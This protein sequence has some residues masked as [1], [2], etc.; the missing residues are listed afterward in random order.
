MTRWLLF[1]LSTT[2]VA[3]FQVQPAAALDVSEDVPVP[4]GIAAVVRVLGVDQ[5]IDRGR[6]VS[7][8][9]RLLYGLPD[10]RTAVADALAQR[11][12]R[13]SSDA[14]AAADLVPVPLTA[15]VWSTAVFHRPVGPADLIAAIIGDRQAALLCHGLAG[16][17]DETLQYLSGHPALITQIYERDAE[18]FSVFASSLHVR[19]G[20]VVPP[21]GDLAAPLWEG[22]LGERLAQPDRFVPALF[23]QADGRTAFLYDTIAALDGPRA[24]FAL[25]LWI[26]DPAARVDAMKRLALAWTSGLRD[27]RVRVQ[28][29]ARQPYDVAA[30]LARV[31]A[32]NDG[33]PAPPQSRALWSR[34]F[35]KTSD[36]DR[37]VDAAWLID[38]TAPVDVR[39][40]HDRLD[41]LAFAQRVFGSAAP[42]D[43]A[44][45]LTALRAF[46]RDRMLMLTFERIGVTQPSM[47]AAAVRRVAAMTPLDTGRAFAATAQFQGALALITRMRLAGT[48]DQAATDRLV[49]SLV[50]VPLTAGGRYA[51]GVTRWLAQQLRPAIPA[52]DTLEDALV[53]AAAGP[54]G[55]ASVNRIQWEG[56]PYVVDLGAAERR[57]IARVREKQG[58]APIDAA[59]ELADVA[60]AC[61]SGTLAPDGVQAATA[62]L[63]S[64]A[65]DWPERSV[66]D[67]PDA[68]PPGV[69]ARPNVRDLI[70]RVVSE[71]DKGDARDAKRAQRVAGALHDAADEATA[72]VLVSLVYAVH[73]GDPDGSALLAGD[74]S[75]RH[76]FGF[77][78]KDADARMRAPWAVPR[79][80]VTPGLA[81]HV[82]GSLLGL[83]VAL[84]TLELRRLSADRALDA[85]TLSANERDTFATSAALVNASAL[86][87][88]ARDAALDAVAR[89]RRRVAAAGGPGDIADELGIDGWRRRSL[90]WTFQHDRGNVESMFSLGELLV[91]GD[92]A[93]ALDRDVWGMAAVA[94]TGCVC[95]EMP[96]PSR[97]LALTGRAQLGVLATAVVDLNLHVAERLKQL[98]LP[99]RLAKFVLGAAVQDFVDE[100]RPSDADDWLT[101]VRTARK[102]SRERIEDYVA[103]AAAAGPLVPMTAVTR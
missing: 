22:V 86:S 9:T 51:G 4:G 15:G 53:G 68:L 69:D 78:V 59:L 27:W 18:A 64:I 8:L 56:Q 45:V 73:I 35:D 93:R 14:G 90:A 91:L 88:A 1:L 82:D 13:L 96:A 43:V 29:F 16:L 38:A 65:M 79:Q 2:I 99:A 41:E 3:A 76:D 84:A 40:R 98:A 31:R 11:I 94:T 33:A 24:A 26:T 81:W 66:R 20:H 25:G 37:P 54:S 67:D 28:P 10:R 44:D 102:A 50:A 49:A 87:D 85:P 32:G 48:L 19:D 75:P 55:G 92:P 5:P 70:G 83:D 39:L 57:R 89:G 61:A 95:N 47:Y 63:R 103:A 46:P 6:F 100:V 74:I 30:T 36:D 71:L 62:R 7:E 34:V 60:R 12:A 17:D 80:D 58:G 42:S 101:L 72:Q 77:G 52:A 97:W 23:G 21:G